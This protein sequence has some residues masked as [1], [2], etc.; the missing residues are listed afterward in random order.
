MAQR[1]RVPHP[2]LDEELALWQK[3]YHVIGIDEV[4]RG[5]FA[6]PL[7][8]GAVVYSPFF[9]DS[10]RSL[11]ETLREV[12]DSKMLP[13]KL[14]T[15]LAKEIS[16]QAKYVAVSEISVKVINRV[17]VGKANQIG[18]RTAIQKIQKHFGSSKLFVLADGFHAKYVRGIGLRNQ[19]AIVGGDK[20]NFSIASASIIAKVYRDNLMKK[21]SLQYIGYG[22]DRHKGYG[23]EIHRQH[24]GELGLT[25]IHRRDFCRNVLT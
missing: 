10:F 25:A 7:V 15:L 17:G 3:G 18:F 14:R 4:G 21:L 1:N 24:I 13:E 20:K 8:V 9:A 22:L 12:H 6:G 2:T 19:K 16:S 11:P 23:T 5:A